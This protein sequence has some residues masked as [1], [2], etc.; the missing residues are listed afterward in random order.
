MTPDSQ[1][2]ERDRVLKLGHVR[3]DLMPYEH[4]QYNS[5]STYI[6]FGTYYSRYIPKND[7]T[8]KQRYFPLELQRL[9]QAFE[10]HNTI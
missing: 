1:L 9:R 2:F 10:I 8:L 6:S 4:L 5:I 7:D 3:Q